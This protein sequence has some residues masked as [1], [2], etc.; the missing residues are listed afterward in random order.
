V[1]VDEE[2]VQ[3]LDG[4]PVADDQTDGFKFQI[5][6]ISSCSSPQTQAQ[7]HPFT[8]QIGTK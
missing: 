1:R 5:G 3:A 7:S 6:Y 4:I 2:E 8:N